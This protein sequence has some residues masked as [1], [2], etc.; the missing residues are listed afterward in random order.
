MNVAEE[1]RQGSQKNLST[2]PSS[3][4]CYRSDLADDDHAGKAAVRMAYNTERESMAAEA[5]RVRLRG[6]HNFWYMKVVLCLVYT[7]VSPKDLLKSTNASASPLEILIQL[8]RIRSLELLL[9]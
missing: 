2:N 1:K 6:C 7:L 9:F 4:T 3:R 5:E 8:V